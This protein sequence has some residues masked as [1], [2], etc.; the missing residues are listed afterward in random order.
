ME[1]E[2]LIKIV[3]IIAGLSF[4]AASLFISQIT[5]AVIGV[6]PANSERIGFFIAAFAMILTGIFIWL[7]FIYYK[8]L[9]TK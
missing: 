9:Y 8:P 6:P 1:K 5:G 3:E 4:I 2:N 7:R